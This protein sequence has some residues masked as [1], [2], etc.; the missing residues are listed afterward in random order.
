MT[1]ANVQLAFSLLTLLTA[2]I[3][4]LL[5]DILEALSLE[6]FLASSSAVYP[7][8]W[9]HLLKEGSPIEFLQ[10]LTLGICLCIAGYSTWISKRIGKAALASCF[11]LFTAGLLLMLAEDSLNV[12]HLTANAYLLPTTEVFV[13][14]SIART[15]WEVFFFSLLSILMISPLGMLYMC[16]TT[17]AEIPSR[18]IAGYAIYGMIGFGS[19][20]RS[21]SDWQERLGNWLIGAFDLAEKKAWSMALAR[22]ER[23]LKE[24]PDFTFTTGYLLFDHLI[25]ESI[26]LIAASLLLSGFIVLF[27]RIRR[28]LRLSTPS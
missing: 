5:V 14:P 8:I 2:W 1:F 20:L 11:F 17:R 23:A 12:R 6:D 15:I 3:I 18:L 25:E 24:N 19:A 21:L 28:R 26:E 22:S 16:R 13:D 9:Y 4:V 7:L 27:F 10:W